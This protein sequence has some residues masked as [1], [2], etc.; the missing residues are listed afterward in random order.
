MH[1]MYLCR[2]VCMYD[3][4]CERVSMFAMVKCAAVLVGGGDGVGR[5][6]E[7]AERC[8]DQLSKD[9]HTRYRQ[10]STHHIS[11]SMAVAIL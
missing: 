1:A 10:Y 4:V 5:L 11:L 2:H 7:I 9:A 8:A 3:C 6:T